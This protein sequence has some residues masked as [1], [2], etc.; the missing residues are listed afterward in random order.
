MLNVGIIKREKK[1]HSIIL[2]KLTLFHWG[3]NNIMSNAEPK[4]FNYMGG[5]RPEIGDLVSEMIYNPNG[6][7]PYAVPET[8][9]Y[10][11]VIGFHRP[12]A[13]E[14]PVIKWINKQNAKWQLPQMISLVA[15]ASK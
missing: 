3:K 6:I 10:G 2:R 8:I 13:T 5:I 14:S 12:R 1:L 15:R 11:I 7:A 9:S 4:R